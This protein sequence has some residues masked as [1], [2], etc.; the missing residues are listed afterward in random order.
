[1]AQT[2]V[3]IQRAYR[4]RLKKR[5]EE[6]ALH[7]SLAT[8]FQIAIRQLAMSGTEWAINV[9]AD[10]EQQ[11]VERLEVMANKAPKRRRTSKKV[12]SN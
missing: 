12:L 1:M 2:Q 5:Q 3:E 7:A 9:A 4:Q 10:T 11:T 6:A 8:R